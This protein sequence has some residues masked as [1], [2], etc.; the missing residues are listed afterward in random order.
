MFTKVVNIYIY[1][2]ILNCNIIVIEIVVYRNCRISVC[3]IF[4]NE[5]V[6]VFYKMGDF[7]PERHIWH[8]FESAV[9]CHLFNT[10][11]FFNK[12]DYDSMF[13]IKIR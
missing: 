9:L 10:F 13:V 2:P 8:I 6:R 5:L 7:L 12:Y 11:F 4:R 1:I 3:F